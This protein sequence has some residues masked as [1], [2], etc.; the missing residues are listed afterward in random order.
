MNRVIYYLI[1]ALLTFNLK[2]N[3]VQ[4]LSSNICDSKQ[5]TQDFE[6]VEETAYK[7][8]YIED[9]DWSDRENEIFQ[10]QP[11]FIEADTPV[12]QTTKGHYS[13]CEKDHEEKEVEYNEQGNESNSSDLEFNREEFI[14]EEEG[15]S[16]E[17]NNQI[18]E[19]VEGGQNNDETKEQEK[20]ENESQG[21]TDIA[22]EVIESEEEKLP[23]KQIQ[24]EE[25]IKSEY[26]DYIEQENSQENKPNDVTQEDESDNRQESTQ[27]E[28]ETEN[29]SDGKAEKEKLPEVGNQVE[30]NEKEDESKNGIQDQQASENQKGEQLESEV[31]SGDEETHNKE[32]NLKEEQVS[33]EE[34]KLEKH[35][36]FMESITNRMG[37][38][39]EQDEVIE[40]DLDLSL[41]LNLSRNN[42]LDLNGY[43]LEI[44]GNLNHIQ[45]RI[46]V[47]NG[48]LV[49][50][51]DYN[52]DNYKE[53]TWGKGRLI[54]ENPNDYVYVAGDMNIY[55][56]EGIKDWLNGILHLKG[57]LECKSV[58][59]GIAVEV[60]LWSQLKIILDGQDNQWIQ[61]TSSG[62]RLPAIIIEGDTNR[63]IDIH[64]ACSNNKEKS[65]IIDHMINNVE[66][67]IELSGPAI[68]EHLVIQEATTIKGDCTVTNIVL[69]GNQLIVDDNLKLKKSISFNKG[70]VY[71]N[72]SMELVVADSIE[73]KEAEDLL[74]IQGDLKMIRCLD[75]YLDKGK[76]II[77]GNIEQSGKCIFETAQELEVMLLS[78]QSEKTTIIGPY[79]VLNN[80][81]LVNKEAQYD[82]GKDVIYQLNESD[83]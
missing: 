58:N 49:I 51:G 77:G 28:G 70:Q 66:T 2:P 16:A 71:V 81:Q 12:E 19:K 59:D 64:Y 37:W 7:Y 18:D 50:Y 76:L 1:V 34:S 27:Q 72:G 44:R 73:M 43:K 69:N 60:P 75:L 82:F 56:V 29:I 3:Q 46:K 42:T 41:S 36:R 68:I 32:D 25:D 45:G 57:N 62:A 30:K 80:V 79:I 52:M 11:I 21:R 14:Q 33:D 54:L 17:D 22:L 10:K 74:V 47:N 35:N 38:V 4:D 15:Q 9:Y 53:E 61:I 83:N 5:L 48:M 40:G 26:E 63:I 8:S 6:D 13:I 20:Q 24:L 78:S 67:T 23:N 39:L 55:A 31:E 65:M